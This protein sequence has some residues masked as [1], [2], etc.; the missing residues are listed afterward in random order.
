MLSMAHAD[1]NIKLL[2]QMAGQMFCT[3]YAAVLAAGTAK[4]EHKVGKATFQIAPYVGIRQ[5][6]YAVQKSEH[7]AVIFQKFNYGGIKA[8]QFFVWFIAAGVMC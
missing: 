4:T 6:V 3:V 7:F 5:L 2:I 8:S 1:F